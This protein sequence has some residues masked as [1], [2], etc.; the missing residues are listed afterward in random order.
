MPRKQPVKYGLSGLNRADHD[1]LSLRRGTVS[2]CVRRDV[3]D[4]AADD[5]GLSG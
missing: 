2:R 5:V 1:I 4:R 3:F